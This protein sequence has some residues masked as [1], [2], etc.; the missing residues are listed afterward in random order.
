MNNKRCFLLLSQE[1]SISFTRFTQIIAAATAAT[2]TSGLGW[3][4]LT[5]LIDSLG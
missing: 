3:H 5:K 4:L 2:S 1:V